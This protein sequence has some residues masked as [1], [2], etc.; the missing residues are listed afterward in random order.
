MLKLPQLR[1][2]V[3]G[4]AVVANVKVIHLELDSGRARVVDAA[5]GVAGWAT[6]IEVTN[7]GGKAALQ[8]VVR[9]VPAGKRSVLGLL[10]DMA[11]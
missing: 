10:T 2:N 4:Q 11:C 3:P 7:L 5:A 6:A 8:A 1:R 9:K